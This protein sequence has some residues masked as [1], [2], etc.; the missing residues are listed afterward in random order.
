MIT[1]AKAVWTSF[2]PPSSYA[3]IGSNLTGNNT[4]VSSGT[5]TQTLNVAAN[6]FIIA[7]I[8][9]E[10]TSLTCTAG[11][12][13]MSLY[14]YY[15]QDTYCRAYVFSYFQVAANNSLAVTTSSGT[16][17]YLMAFGLTGVPSSGQFEDFHT[18]QYDSVSGTTVTEGGLTFTG[19]TPHRWEFQFMATNYV[20]HTATSSFGSF[21]TGQNSITSNI[22]TNQWDAGNVNYR[23]SSGA[24]SPTVTL[25]QG[26]AAQSVRI[27]TMIFA[28]IPAQVTGGGYLTPALYQTFNNNNSFGFNASSITVNMTETPVNGDTLFLVIGTSPSSG[29]TYYTVSASGISQT[30]VTWDASAVV[31]KTNSSGHINVEIWKGIVGV[32]ASTS[33]TITLS[34]TMPALSTYE[35]D[36]QE[37][38]NIA[39][40]PTDKT[41]TASGTSSTIASGTTASTTKNLELCIVGM[42]TD[43]SIITLPA[44]S[45][46]TNSYT[47]SNSG[48]YALGT[49]AY[50]VQTTAAT[51][52][53]AATSANSLDYV[54]VIA[55]FTSTAQTST[56]VGESSVIAG[57][58]MRQCSMQLIIVSGSIVTV[59]FQ[60]SPDNI[61]WLNI[62]S[63]L[64]NVAG[65][66]SKPATD[67]YA[68]YRAVVTAA[69]GSTV[70]SVA[71]V[72]TGAGTE[73]VSGY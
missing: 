1:R 31:T 62:G 45:S 32:G 58:G 51:E 71:I 60:G 10:T 11:G 14:H 29:T 72:G 39:S 73:I 17:I 66:V 54:G 49:L 68:Y 70:I 30:G 41:S 40:S 6:T 69:D 27:I 5:A 4:Y 9:C 57:A 61:N 33:I 50:F 12:N 53:T 48:T 37:W 3:T 25:T 56:D 13:A 44:F 20:T 43:G 26:G 34:G 36:I 46:P 24:D 63:A 55:T 52:S 7:C 22:G 59:Q 38:S 64:V 47:L 23:V 2:T 65:L 21:G 42:M 19:G 28:V 18:E 16:E 67:V 8:T 15:L 35:L